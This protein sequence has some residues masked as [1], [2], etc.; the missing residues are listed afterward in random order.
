[1]NK[2]ILLGNLTKNIEIRYSQ[3]GLAIGKTSIA[4]N[5][6]SK[7]QSGEQKNEVMFVDITF[8]GRTAEIANQYFRKGSKILIEGRLS[9]DQWT[10]QSGMK[11]SKHSVIAETLEF[12][13]SKADANNSNSQW[14][15]NQNQGSGSNNFNDNNGNYGN[16][17]NGGYQNNQSNNNY[18]S[19]DNGYN[20]KATQNSTPSN[21]NSSQQPQ[22]DKVPE[23]DINDMDDQV[24]F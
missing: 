18:S 2:V 6:R 21:I 24:P 22:A 4:T 23:I 15:N 1:M 13:E 3:A 17:N 12:V 16:N 7:T 14:N 5:R 11:R 9:F 10:D 20:Q 19:Q 8:F